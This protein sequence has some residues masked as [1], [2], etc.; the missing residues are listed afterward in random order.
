MGQSRVVEETASF[1]DHPVLNLVEQV[2]DSRVA[3]DNFHMVH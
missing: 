3:V 1:A 2:R